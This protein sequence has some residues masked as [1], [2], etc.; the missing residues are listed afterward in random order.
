MVAVM[1]SEASLPE[2]D[3]SIFDRLPALKSVSVVSVKE[4]EVVDRLILP[5]MAALTFESLD[6]YLVQLV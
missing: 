5:D 3:I 2:P 6:E 1:V 4:D